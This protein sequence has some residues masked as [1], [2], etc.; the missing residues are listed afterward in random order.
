MTL[1]PQTEFTVP[2]ETARVAQAAFPN[3]N[4]YLRLHDELGQLYTDADFA[5]LFPRRGQPALSPAQLAL[6][7]VMQFAEGLTD[8]QAADAVASRID[9][10]YALGLE[11]TDPS[12]H[13]SVLSEF[14]DRLLTGDAEAGLFE[15]LLRRCREVG[16]LRAGGRQRTDSTHVVAAIK[17]LNRLELVV[18]TL[19][20]TLDVL[21]TAAPEWLRDHLD[22]AWVD[23][24]GRRLDD[25]R[26]PQTTAA[27]A[28]LATTVGTD[29]WMLLAAITAPGAPAWLG[30]LPAVVSLWQIWE[31]QY[32]PPDV[33]DQVRWRA[34][35][36]L[37][38]AAERQASPHDPDARQGAKRETHWLGYKVHL[39]ETCDSDRPSLI[40][41]VQ[42][43]VATTQDVR[44]TGT[45]QAALDER[46]LAPAVQLVDTGYLSADIRVTS[47]TQHQITVVGPTHPDTHWQ[48][49]TPGAYTID[50]FTIDWDAPQAICPQG[51]TSIAWSE[52]Q[53]PTGR[54]VITTRF[55]S[56]AC[57][58]CPV[59]ERCTH[60][61]RGG[62]RLTLQPPAQ[63]AAHTAAR[64]F[65]QTA[66]FTHAYAARAGIEGLI[67]Q[68]VRAFG[69]RRARYRGLAKTRLQ[70]LLTATALNLVRLD[71]WLA[72]Q[73]RATTRPNKLARLLAPDPAA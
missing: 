33:T 18:E 31:Q 63:Q 16:L 73:P 3:G 34:V 24:Y 5:A 53:D 49:R 7:T 27:R 50:A 40:T 48:A 55:P 28:A 6:V 38:V 22:P 54:V 4:H 56:A 1:H 2:D 11:L 35:A 8:R 70:H 37:P 61:A 57:Q 39:T 20:H 17:A 36:E 32:Q 23:R 59:R 66:D 71:A 60:S 68:G 43:T 64:A 69:L 62:R 30:D 67:S 52:T 13:Y 25:H 19:H 26:L 14:R 10:K 51:Q 15:G 47:Q 12:F 21:A 65:E 41:D 29:G 44:L 46:G 45:I 58:A 42:T 9:W 72:E